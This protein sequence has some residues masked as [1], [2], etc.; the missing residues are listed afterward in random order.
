MLIAELQHTEALLTEKQRAETP[1]LLVSLD[2]E[3]DTP[4]KLLALE[5]QHHVDGKRWH[6]TRTVEANVRKIA[7]LLGVRYRKLPD[8]TIGHS[9]QVAVLDRNGVLVT[10]IEGTAGDPAALAATVTRL[11]KSR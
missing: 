9:A 8:G 6:F 11:G 2:P 7:A 3:R 1:I 5:K 4:A 10:R